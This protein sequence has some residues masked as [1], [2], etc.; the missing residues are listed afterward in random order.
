MKTLIFLMGALGLM[1]LVLSGFLVVNTIS[2]LL[3]QQVRQIGILKSIGAQRKQ[4]IGVYLVM[5]LTFGGLSLLIAAM[6]QR[7]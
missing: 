4:I 3:L 5:V 2:S 1:S 7:G 6:L